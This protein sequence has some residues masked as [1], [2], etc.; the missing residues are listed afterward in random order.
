[1]TRPP[2]I[3]QTGS[4]A[5]KTKGQGRSRTL[6][7]AARMALAWLREGGEFLARGEAPLRLVPRR[8]PPRRQLGGFRQRAEHRIQSGNKANRSRG[9]AGPGNG[10]GRARRRRPAASAGSAAIPVGGR[11][12]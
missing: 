3:H 11:M 1:M 10:R 9:F 7:F 8:R 4:V 6:A 12:V 2:W 5:T